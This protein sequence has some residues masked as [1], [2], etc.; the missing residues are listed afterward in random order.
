MG[1]KSGF[2][3][4]LLS[5]LRK[6]NVGTPFYFNDFEDA[7]SNSNFNKCIIIDYQALVFELM[8]NH[9]D[10]IPMIYGGEFHKWELLITSFIKF[11]T[12]LGF[13]G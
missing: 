13:I 12:N 4:S 3:S 10:T 8:R 7:F 6:K 1:L 2:S 11:L 9:L 5:I